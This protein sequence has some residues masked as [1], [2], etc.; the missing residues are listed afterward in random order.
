MVSAES[1][2]QV[3]CRALNEMKRGLLIL[4]HTTRAIKISNMAYEPRG[5]RTARRRIRS[6]RLRL[7]SIGIWC[8]TTCIYA[9]NMLNKRAYK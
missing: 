4:M 2:K 7:F 8:K 3:E 9:Q 1:L 5:E 6:K